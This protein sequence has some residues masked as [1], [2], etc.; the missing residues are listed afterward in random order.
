MLV[1]SADRKFKALFTPRRRPRLPPGAGPPRPPRRRG[2]SP[3]ERG[4][5]RSGQAALLGGQRLGGSFTEVA[6]LTRWQLG[7]IK[8]EV[9]LGKTLVMERRPGLRF[10]WRTDQLEPGRKIVQTC[11]EGPGASSGKTLT[12]SLSDEPHGRTLVQLSDAGWR[13]DDPHLPLC[14]TYWGEALS[15]LCAYQENSET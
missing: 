1:R 14:N 3:G 2:C 4:G 12:I 10:G 13:E 6:G 8:G 15:R 11:V 9:D 5:A 7:A